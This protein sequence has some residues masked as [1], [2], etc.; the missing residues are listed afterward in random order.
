MNS[1][2]CE[3]QLNSLIEHFNNGG[4]DFNATDIEAIKHLLLE[5]Q[6]QHNEIKQRNELI[7]TVRRN[8]ELVDYYGIKNQMFIWIEEMSELTKVICKWARKYD[9]LDGDLTP[10]LKQD[11][12]EEIAD[13][14]V[15]L[16]QI[17]YAIKL[18]EDEIMKEYKYKVDRQIERMK[19]DK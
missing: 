7:E 4:L 2:E 15:S 3:E 6:I 8:V 16:D 13:V 9:E 14:T 17:K 11:F 19:N 12:L 18:F 5:N 10:Q 1:K